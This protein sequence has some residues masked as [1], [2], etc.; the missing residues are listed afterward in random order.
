MAMADVKRP[1]SPRGSS[2]PA[3]PKM[4][5]KGAEAIGDVLARFM[6]ASPVG[7]E[8][9]REALAAAWKDAVG[10]EVAAETRVRG[11]RDG[12]LTVEVQSSALLSELS[13]FYRASIL[14]ALRARRGEKVAEVKDIS[15]KLGVIS[16]P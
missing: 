4:R 5:P 7:R 3:A 2:P 16:K 14:A 12:V 10:A 13:T 9:S 8:L 15:F 1:W 11:W 6:A